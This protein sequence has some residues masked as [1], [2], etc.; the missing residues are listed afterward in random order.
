MNIKNQIKFNKI[1][2]SLFLFKNKDKR[3]KYIKKFIV[4]KSQ[5]GVFF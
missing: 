3:W 2:L 1:N 4:F 5:K